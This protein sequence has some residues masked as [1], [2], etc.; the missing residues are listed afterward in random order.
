MAGEST[1]NMQ[2]QKRV[3]GLT[4][5][6]M[7]LFKL[8]SFQCDTYLQQGAPAADL[9][10]VLDILHNGLL[11]VAKKAIRDALTGPQVAVAPP[12]LRVA[13]S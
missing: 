13:R 3:V 7:E 2:E 6:Q 12:G 5:N 11:E 1:Q 10:V 8:L 9:A 4:A